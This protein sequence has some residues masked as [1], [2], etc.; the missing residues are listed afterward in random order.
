MLT[1]IEGIKPGRHV[2][3][4]LRFSEIGPVLGRL[5][6]RL[7]AP[8]GEPGAWLP[9][10]ANLALLT[11][12]GAGPWGPARREKV[13]RAACEWFTRGLF[14]DLER[15]N[16]A[17]VTLPFPLEWQNRIL[18]ALILSLQD[19]G[20]DFSG[21]CARWRIRAARGGWRQV[22]T[23]LFRRAG[24]D[25]L[26]GMKVLWLFARDYLGCPAFCMD[27][28]VKRFI[29]GLGLP[30]DP[31]LLTEVMVDA[32]VDPSLLSRQVFLMWSRNPRITG[33]DA[34]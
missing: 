5:S 22:L 29:R 11:A 14:L 30:A 27:R 28:H 24:A 23:E 17:E 13:Q 2:C 34:A 18:R 8:E 1:S 15:V 20:A 12:I 19:D 4:T 32:R 3:E 16:I 10:D 9:K 25:P 33:G 7:P 6:K 31:W 26:D 21:L